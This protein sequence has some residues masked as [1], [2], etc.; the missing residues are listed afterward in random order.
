MRA[1]APAGALAAAALLLSS[2]PANAAPLL[3]DVVAD[4]PVG[5]YEHEF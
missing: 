5:G 1:L 4:A 2:A 3:P